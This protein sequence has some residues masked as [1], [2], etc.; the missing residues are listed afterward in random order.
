MKSDLLEALKAELATFKFLQHRRRP[1]TSSSGYRVIPASEAGRVL[2]EYQKSSENGFYRGCMAEVDNHVCYG[3]SLILCEVVGN[4]A[5]TCFTDDVE[6]E[7]LDYYQSFPFPDG[8]D[9]DFFINYV[10]AQAAAL[11][12]YGRSDLGELTAAS[13]RRIEEYRDLAAA[14]LKAFKLGYVPVGV[15]VVGGV[16]RLVVWWPEFS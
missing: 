4:E 14:K 8:G 10:V 1:E 11:P 13:R 3:A 12:L 5:G 15:D 16:D 2:D 6:E 9:S 7:I